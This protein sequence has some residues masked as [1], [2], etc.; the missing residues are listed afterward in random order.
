LSHPEDISEC[1]DQ[2]SGGNYPPDERQE[3]IGHSASLLAFWREHS[4][5][6]GLQPGKKLASI[7]VLLLRDLLAVECTQKWSAS[8]DEGDGGGQ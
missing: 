1:A 2:T 6:I 3:C 5:T 8:K 4:S 7:R